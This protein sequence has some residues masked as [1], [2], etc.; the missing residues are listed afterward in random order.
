MIC[1]LL[2]CSVDYPAIMNSS[3]LDYSVFQFFSYLSIYYFL[4]K[5]HKMN[6]TNTYLERRIKV[7]YYRKQVIQYRQCSGICC[8]PHRTSKYGTRPFYGESRCRAVAHAHPACSKNAFGPVGIPL[9][10]RLRHRAINPTLLKEVKAWGEGPLR[11]KDIHKKCLPG[12]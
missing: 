12:G 4:R 6:K 8:S 9:L 2:R 10:G 1:V 7:I 3:I 5:G 11:P